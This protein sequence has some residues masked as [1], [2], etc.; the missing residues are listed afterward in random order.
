M[1]TRSITHRYQD[2]LDLVWLKAAS[3]L[4]IEVRRSRSVYASWDGERVLT[5]SDSSDFDADDSLAQLILH[6]IC[7]ALVAAP[8]QRREADWGLDNTSERDLVYEHA[9]HRLQASLSGRH[10][11]RDFFAVTTEWR[12]YWD[13][14]P[15]DPLAACDDPALPIARRGSQEAERAPWAEVLTRAFEDTAALASIARRNAGQESL[16]SVTRARHASGFLAHDDASLRCAD[17]AWSHG[18]G[19]QLACRQASR[20]GRST[21]RLPAQTPACELWE[22]KLEPESCK[23]C[24]ACCREGFDRVELRPSDSL[25]KRH[26]ELVREDSWGVFIPR[27]DGRCL[28]LQG[29][30]E[31]SAFRCAVYADRPHSCQKFEIGGAACLV[32]RRRVGLSG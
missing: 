13:A 19:K 23:T 21:L 27:P 14:L 22:A 6:E 4:G 7:H 5:L 17:C 26:P 9:C 28:G 10:G 1:T 32:A 8:A 31:R 3:E 29:D 16:W 24:G 15:A 18:R 12:S 25:R 11:L 30:G 20:S 2:P